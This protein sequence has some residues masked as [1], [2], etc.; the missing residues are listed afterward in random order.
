M[1]EQELRMHLSG[2]T[3]NTSQL[4]N[5]FEELTL[6]NRIKPTT[7]ENGRLSFETITKGCGQQS[8]EEVIFELIKDAGSSGILFIDIRLRAKLPEHL[9][10]KELQSLV[11]KK[12]VTKT[13]SITHKM[14]Y[15]IAGLKADVLLTGNA[16]YSAGTVAAKQ[17]HNLKAVC[18]KTIYERHE[19][20][21]QQ[22][23][24]D[25]DKS[26]DHFHEVDLDQI[27]A[28][29]ACEL[30]DHFSTLP[31]NGSFPN[32][33]LVDIEHILDIL[34]FEGKLIKIEQLNTMPRY[35]YNPYNQYK[36]DHF[37]APCMDC[38]DYQRCLPQS[39]MGISPEICSLLDLGRLEWPRLIA[40]QTYILIPLVMF[41]TIL[42]TCVLIL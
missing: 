41:L 27:V 33:K 8:P 22:M 5:A 39:A 14:V 6:K 35:R 1:S 7:D 16:L 23:M 18:L 26:V 4:Q 40:P 20:S 29:S 30:F 15:T 12:L 31:E 13:K 36:K 42:Q 37:Y 3:V 25:L 38:P 11:E 32:L 21:Y 17:V 28:V 24:I 34:L 10:K 19:K 2:A 9:L